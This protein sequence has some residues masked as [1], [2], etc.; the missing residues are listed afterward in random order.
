[1]PNPNSVVGQHYKGG[2]TT[3][4]H[5]DSFFV[6]K[7]PINDCQHDAMFVL[8]KR[9]SENRSLPRE[10]PSEAPRLALAQM[11]PACASRM[12]KTSPCAGRNHKAIL[13]TGFSEF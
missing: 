1:M 13:R 7:H 5:K 8:P 2:T 10:R 11:D 3:I 6:N 9:D 12:T 4:W